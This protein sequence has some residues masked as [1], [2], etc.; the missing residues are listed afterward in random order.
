MAGLVDTATGAES[1]SA[2][3][4]AV[5]AAGRLDILKGKEPFTVFAPSDEAVKGLPKGVLQGLLRD[6]DRLD[7]MVK[8]H[9]AAGKYRVCCIRKLKSLKTLAGQ[10]ITF[11]GQ[12]TLRVDDIRIIRADIESENGV[13]HII[14]GLIQ[15][16]SRP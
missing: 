9:V 7:R 16:H 5:T 1:F 11:S 8:R 15:P 14:D 6:P 2:M 12:E 4:Q 10:E 3:L 13:V